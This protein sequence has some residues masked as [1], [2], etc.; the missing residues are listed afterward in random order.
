MATFG[1]EICLAFLHIIGY[2]AASRSPLC[3]A[4]LDLGCSSCSRLKQCGLV[5]ARGRWGQDVAATA[6]RYHIGVASPDEYKQQLHRSGDDQ[7]VRLI[8]RTTNTWSHYQE[9]PHEAQQAISMAV[10]VRWWRCMFATSVPVTQNVLRSS[11]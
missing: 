9:F 11:R 2:W 6:S 10:L 7:R 3:G 8:G 5:G 4:A 1:D